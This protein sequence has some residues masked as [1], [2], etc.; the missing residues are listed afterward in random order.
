MSPTVR[1]PK[2]EKPQARAKLTAAKTKPTGLPT[3][4]KP[5]VTR[6]NDQRA[7]EAGPQPADHLAPR[8]PGAKQS[9]MAW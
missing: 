2:C 7:D 5:S 6:F 1:I 9:R 3:S 8:V 4:A